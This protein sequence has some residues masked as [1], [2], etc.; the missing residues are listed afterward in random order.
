[1]KAMFHWARRNDVLETIPNIDVISKGKVVRKRMYT[2]NS[3][4]IKKLLSA[5]NVK[6]KA[7]IWL[8]L[9]LTSLTKAPLATRKIVF[10]NNGK[11]L[12]IKYNVGT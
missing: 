7:M 4:Q 10:N 3:Q 11:S 12:W 5:A 8:I 2:F 9:Q 1:M 6:M